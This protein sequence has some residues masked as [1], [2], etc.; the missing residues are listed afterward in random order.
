MCK[1][2]PQVLLSAIP[3]LYETEGKGN[4]ICHIKLFLPDSNWTWYI[5]EISK[6]D[7][8]T[9]FGYVQGLDGELGFFTLD[10]LESVQGP[11]G[12]AIERDMSFEPTAF[13]NIR[14]NL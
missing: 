2:I 12:L 7:K 6:A 10:E 9:C 14:K 8:K 4:P 3:D 13:S 5:M 1:L 11:L